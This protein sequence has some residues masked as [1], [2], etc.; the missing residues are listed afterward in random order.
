MPVSSASAPRLEPELKLEAPVAPEIEAKLRG[1]GD[2]FLFD[3]EGR[4]R[5]PETFD[6]LM[7]DDLKIDEHGTV[8]VREQLPVERLILQTEPAEEDVEKLTGRM[9]GHVSALPVV[10]RGTDGRHVVTRFAARVRYCE[11]NELRFVWCWMRVG[12][13]AAGGVS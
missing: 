8:Y 10:K 7:K 6:V 4:P 9:P 1:I 11:R 2:S 13:M 12:K 3:C 5:W